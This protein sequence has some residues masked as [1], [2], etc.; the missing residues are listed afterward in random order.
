MTS[1]AERVADF[2]LT[3]IQQRWGRL[4][5]GGK[6]PTVSGESLPKDC[7]LA[8]IAGRRVR[9]ITDIVRDGLVAWHLHG[10]PVDVITA[11][12]TAAEV[13][14][15]QARGGRFV[16][17]V[18]DEAAAAHG[19]PRHPDGLRFALHDLEHLEK[20][21]APEHHVGQVGFFRAVERSLASPAIAQVQKGFDDIWCADRDYV[22]A[23]MNGSAV[24][25]FAVLKMK[26]LMAV[27]RQRETTHVAAPTGGPL[28]PSE[29]A[30]AAPAIAT[31]VRGF[32]LSPAAEAAATAVSARRDHP[33]AAQC[34]LAGFEAL[35]HASVTPTFSASP[36]GIPASQR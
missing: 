31:L 16:S 14:A 12:P 18:S 8:V 13:L 2:L 24:F 6:R 5:D 35:A 27:R 33:A 29:Q 11:I 15:R 26:V 7:A 23:D 34:L 17:L 10:R 28:S 21:V 22:I 20:F 4:W 19:D 9:G 32:A 1:D 25:L 3:R 36:T 30:R